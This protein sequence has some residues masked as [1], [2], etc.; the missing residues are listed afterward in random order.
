MTFRSLVIAKNAILLLA[1]SSVDGH[2]SLVAASAQEGQHSAGDGAN[3]IGMSSYVVCPQVPTLHCRNGSTCESGMATIHEQHAH[4]NLQT[5]ESGYHCVCL[6]GYIGHECQVEVDDCDAVTGYDPSDATGTLRS[7]Y[8]GSKC[9]AY[10]SSSGGSSAAAQHYCDCESINRMSGPTAQK[11]AGIM[12]QH[13]STSM[14]AASLVVASSSS[15]SS[16]SSPSSL[17]SVGTHS[18]NGQFCANHGTCVRMVSGDEPHPGCVCKD[19]WTGMHCAEKIPTSVHVTAKMAEEEAASKKG[20]ASAVAGN[21]LLGCY[22]VAIAAVALCLSV[23][24]S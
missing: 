4:L 8:H 1:A 24:L 12:C 20:V 3:N 7:C 9:R 22:L 16:S 2:S 23:A 19:G 10:S 17:S 13:A 11:F 21:V 15:S 6:P 18:P 5:H 14:C